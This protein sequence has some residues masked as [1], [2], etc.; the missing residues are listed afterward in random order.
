MDKVWTDPIVVA[1][2]ALML[3]NIG[4]GMANRRAIPSAWLSFIGRWIRCAFFSLAIFVLLRHILPDRHGALLL[5]GSV[6]VYFFALSVL[7]WIQLSVFNMADFSEGRRYV[8]CD[9]AWRP[10]PPLLK[11]K[12]ILQER[13]FS[14]I[15]AF[16]ASCDNFD[17][18]YATV[19]Q[20]VGACVRLVVAFV[21]YGDIW[22]CV[23]SAES[24]LE[25]GK[26][27]YTEASQL[28]FG[29]EYP[30]NYD[31]KKV[32]LKSN[33]L[34]L[35]DMHLARLDSAESVPVPFESGAEE[36]INGQNLKIE[37]YNRKLGL[38]NPPDMEEEY[39]YLS[40]DGKYR[41]WVE[42]VLV[43]Y[44]PFLLK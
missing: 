40:Q 3:L 9:S 8:K 36:F 38:I 23:S 37:K 11:L 21:P 39:G 35:L 6:V 16:K 32:V 43:N 13:G 4:L 28:P 5:I 10:E 20:N 33:P 15:G 26:T 44:F 25:N 29:L 27:I 17:M 18:V 24:I 22:R 42:M 14:Q 34:S 30:D 31:A 1:I 12:R 41:V 19:F 7:Y 2:A